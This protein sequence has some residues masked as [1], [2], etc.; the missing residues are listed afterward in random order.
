MNLNRNLAY[1]FVLVPAIWCLITGKEFWPFT[2]FPMYSNRL[3]TF[4]WPHFQVRNSSTGQ[5]E[6]LEKEECF[7]PFGYVRIHFAIIEFYRRNRLD[8]ISAIQ[9][10]LA[11][12][13]TCAQ[14]QWSQLRI[15][16]R[17]HDINSRHATDLRQPVPEVA[18]VK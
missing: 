18:F 4:D 9:S 15:E 5:W 14:G 17:H 11:E 7:A 16:I 6:D 10:Q 12:T 1:S 2:H 3:K 13:T 8:A